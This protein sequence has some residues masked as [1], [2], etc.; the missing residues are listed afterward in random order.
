MRMRIGVTSLDVAMSVIVVCVDL[1][2]YSLVHSLTHVVCS[3]L[4]H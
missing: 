2:S 3:E 4:Q 1:L